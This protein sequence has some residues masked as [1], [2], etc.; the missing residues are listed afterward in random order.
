MQRAFEEDP[1]VTVPDSALESNRLESRSPQPSTSETEAPK[2]SEAESTIS[3]FADLFE[4]REKLL[5]ITRHNLT[6]HS[7]LVRKA[8][9]HLL[10]FVALHTAINIEPFLGSKVCESPAFLFF[11]LMMYDI[12]YKGTSSAPC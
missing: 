4:Y 9:I 12:S 2:S 3:G 8:A 7:A 5:L 10:E 11:L 1:S 6:N